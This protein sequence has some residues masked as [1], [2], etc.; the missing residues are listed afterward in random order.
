MPMSYYVRR[1]VNVAL[2]SKDFL[3]LGIDRFGQACSHYQYSSA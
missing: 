1:I 2:E 3:C